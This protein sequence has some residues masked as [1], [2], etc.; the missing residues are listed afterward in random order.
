MDFF[1]NK[2]IIE[3]SKKIHFSRFLSYGVSKLK[4]AYEVLSGLLGLNNRDCETFHKMSYTFAHYTYI[5]LLSLSLWKR[6]TS[7]IKL[8]IPVI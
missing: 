3:K 4:I 2:K 1:L 6:R 8:L 7:E 5:H